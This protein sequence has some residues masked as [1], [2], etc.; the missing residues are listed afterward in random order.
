MF[1]VVGA[2]LNEAL[3]RQA[4]EHPACGAVVVF[5]GTVRDHTAE[6]RVTHLEYEAY[7][8]MA[9]SEMARIGAEVVAEH[10]LRTLACAH[11]VGRLAI[12][13]VAVIVAASA[14]HRAAAFAGVET[15][16]RRLKEDVPIWKKE[17]FEDGAVWVGSPEDP[18]GRR[19]APNGETT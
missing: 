9:E 4:V 14:P 3:V 2:P 19:S 10:D 7:P 6:R 16:I 5:H 8:G 15:F 11:R 17:H 1:S 18:Q 13:D 12:G